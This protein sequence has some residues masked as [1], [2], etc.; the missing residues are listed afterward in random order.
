[1]YSSNIQK[2]FRYFIDC[3]VAAVGF[4]NYISILS[5]QYFIIIH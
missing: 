2:Y 3:S 5:G 1:M 4:S